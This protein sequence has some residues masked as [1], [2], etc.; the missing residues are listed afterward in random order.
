MLTLPSGGSNA[1]IYLQGALNST[2]HGTLDGN[3]DDGDDD[4]V[5]VLTLSI[6]HFPEI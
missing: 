6:G 3:D 5:D 4:D 1:T 2:C